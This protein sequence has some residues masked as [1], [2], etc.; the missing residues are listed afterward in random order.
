M[1]QPD[2]EEVLYNAAQDQ[3]LLLEQ[4]I[5]F[6]LERNNAAKKYFET[7][8]MNE[9]DQYIKCIIYCNEEIERILCL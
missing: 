4:T 6:L 5:S 1:E 8:N 7:E 2:Y 9:R 3:L